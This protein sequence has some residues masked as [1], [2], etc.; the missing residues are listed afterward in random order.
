[1]I[2]K[3]MREFKKIQAEFFIISVIVG[4]TLYFHN[5]FA[6]TT[7]VNTLESMLVRLQDTICAMAIDQHN[8]K[9]REI[10]LRRE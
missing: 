3:M 1:M 9:A 2:R 4:I 8:S 5:T 10:C 7:R 6:Y